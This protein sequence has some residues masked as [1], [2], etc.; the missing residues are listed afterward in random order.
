MPRGFDRE[1]LA[2]CGTITATEIES[3]SKND[4][5]LRRMRYIWRPTA[6]VASQLPPNFEFPVLAVLGHDGTRYFRD[7][8]DEKSYIFRGFAAGVALLDQLRGFTKEQRLRYRAP[9]WFYQYVQ[10][11]QAHLDCNF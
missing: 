2:R 11:T 4:V 6:L 3:A 5:V 10:E 7:A 9:F 8:D 1:E